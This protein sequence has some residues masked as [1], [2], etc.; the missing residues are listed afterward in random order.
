M[1][2][3]ITAKIPI[4][5]VV[6]D[7]VEK[8][9]QKKLNLPQPSFRKIPKQDYMR[10][11]HTAT[12]YYKDKSKEGISKDCYF[13]YK[14]P[15]QEELNNTVEYDMDLEDINWLEQFNEQNGGTL[16]V[17]DSDFEKIM[18]RLEKESY[19]ESV[20]SGQGSRH[21]V[22]EDA[23]CAV[24][25]IGDCHN[26]NVIIFCDMCDLAVHQECY[27]VPYIPLGQ[28]L[29][30]RCQLSPAQNVECCLCPNL[31][32]AFKQT[33]FTDFPMTTDNNSD[34]KKH[35]IKNKKGWA[36]VVCALWV[37]E[38][39]FANT[40]FLEPIEGIENIDAARWKL[41]C[42]IC[43]QRQKGACIQ[44]S[45][46]NCY[47]PFHVT[48]AKQA[49]LFMRIS[50]FQY[51]R[52]GETFSDVRRF[53]YCDKHTPAGEN[54]K[55]GMYSGD[56]S[57]EDFDSERYRKKEM[58]RKKNIKRARDKLAKQIVEY[59]KEAAIVKVED[60]KL[61]GIAKT[62]RVPKKKSISPGLD[63]IRLEYVQRIHAYWL[64]KRKA[65]NGVP[66]LRRLQ[67]SFNPRTDL[68]IDRNSEEDRYNALRYDVEKA[69][70]LLG[71]M[72]RR[73]NLKTR[74]LRK[75]IEIIKC[76]FD[77]IDKE[78]PADEE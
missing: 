67:V 42:Y 47:Q 64:H 55:A 31:G 48:C 58:F 33:E 66:L 30:K 34:K 53:A 36:H 7:S 23:V 29:C 74:A 62:L 2:L 39:A 61:L 52:D 59:K 37:P 13:H 5:R 25:D 6:S 70:I 14:E 12:K 19:F 78:D 18:D 27:G 77:I 68:C 54:K 35:K 45:K 46:P 1:A 51:E 8:E 38:V 72:K 3:D 63:K 21:D 17:T 43:N 57:D 15:T 9:Q 49:G 32:G 40:V 11:K 75:S 22:D 24:C 44:C 16:R 76:K 10:R 60:D 28:W 65:R 56:E 20:K 26:T 69:R 73:E 4:I 71:E 41:K 50:P